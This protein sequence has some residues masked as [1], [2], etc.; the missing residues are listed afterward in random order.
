MRL[1]LSHDVFCNAAPKRAM[2]VPRG[3]AL[4]KGAHGSLPLLVRAPSPLLA[5]VT[6]RHSQSLSPSTLEAAPPHNADRHS[7]Q[8]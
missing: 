2:S 8:V 4:G 7:V 1:S 5:P 3:E 6:A